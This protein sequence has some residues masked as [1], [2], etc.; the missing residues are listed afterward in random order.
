VVLR[1]DV[2]HE[3]AD[4]VGVAGGVISRLDLR[5]GRAKAVCA[6]IAVLTLD[7]Q[8]PQH[9][10]VE[11]VGDAWHELRRRLDL[12]RAGGGEGRTG[13]EGARREHLAARE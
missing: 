8:G 5:Q 9:D 7:R 12:G 11:P 10:R 4:P 3:L 1:E 13:T 6:G 2:A